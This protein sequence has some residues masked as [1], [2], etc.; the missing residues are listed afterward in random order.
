MGLAKHDKI[1]AMVDKFR[2]L[3]ANNLTPGSFT[4]NVLTLMTGTTFSQALLV[5]VAPILTRIYSPENFGVYALYTS[6]LSIIAVMSCL[7]Y[8]HAIV[9]PEKE[10]DAANILFIS[11]VICFCMTI[12]TL[13]IILFFGKTIADILG[14]PELAHWLWLMPISLLAV[15]LFQILNYWSTRRKQFKRLAVRQITRSTATVISQLGIGI[16]F[17]PVNAGGLIGGDLLGQVVA[18]S[19]LA[20]Q[21]KKEEGRQILNSIQWNTCKQLLSIYKKFPLYSSWASLINTLSAMLPALLLGYFFTPPIVGYF[22][23]AHRVLA[24][25]MGIVGSS[26]GQVFFPEA[27]IKHRQGNLSEITFKIFEQLVSLCMVPIGLLTIISPELFGIIFGSNWVIAGE[28]VRWLSLWIFFQFISS[29]LSTV[30]IVLEK[31][32]GLLVFN[33]FL[34]ATRTITLVIGGIYNNATLTIILFGLSGFIMYLFFT[35]KILNMAGIQQYRIWSVIGL[36]MLKSIPY[37][38]VPV[39]F[40]FLFN[41]SFLFVLSAILAG[42]IFLIQLAYTKKN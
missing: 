11:L 15:G 4:R 38:L 25:P 9:L 7:R 33:I 21:I 32:Q 16:Y 39:V 37:A 3:L 6:I 35:V 10:K 26:L 42:V 1:R 24:M 19:R 17:P 31:Q 18:T 29:P 20:W 2:K 40:R 23:L 5:L 41:N 30:Y 8:E 27:A 28:Y 34:L 13:L 36:K 12:I 22:A 14:S